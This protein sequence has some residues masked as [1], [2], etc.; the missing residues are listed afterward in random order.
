MDECEVARNLFTR[1]FRALRMM[2][3]GRYQGSENSTAKPRN[4]LMGC[5]AFLP[6]DEISKDGAHELT[7]PHRINC[8]QVGRMW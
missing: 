4:L 8:K 6:D 1:W 5:L 2:I 3:E 7:E